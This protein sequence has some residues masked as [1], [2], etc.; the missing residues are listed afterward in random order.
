MVDINS[1]VTWI[2]KEKS[3]FITA[4]TLLLFFS[5]FSYFSLLR[6]LDSLAT[7]G[8]FLNLE[9]KSY[10]GQTIWANITIAQ[11]CD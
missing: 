4:P 6:D 8:S 1:G 2:C 3:E 7:S 10:T 5:P 9:A 11:I